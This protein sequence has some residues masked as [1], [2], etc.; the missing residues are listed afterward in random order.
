VSIT[1]GCAVCPSTLRWR[2]AGTDSRFIGAGVGCAR[3]VAVSS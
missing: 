1:I 3:L 2:I